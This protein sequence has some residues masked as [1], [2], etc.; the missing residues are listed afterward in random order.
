[1]NSFSKTLLLAAGLLG[2]WLPWSSAQAIQL[3][4][5]YL[6][7]CRREVGV[8]LRADRSSVQMLTLAGA[9]RTFPRFEIIY[10]ALYPLGEAPMTR[11]EGNDE[12]DLVTVQTIFHGERRELVRGWMVD[13]AEE[14]ISFLT[15][16]GEETVIDT[17]DIWDLEMAPLEETVVFPE[18]PVFPYR[19]VHPYPFAHCGYDDEAPAE[20]GVTRRTIFPQTQ[21]GDP[22]LIKKELDRLEEG[23]ARTEGYRRSKKFYPVPQV[24]RNETQLGVGAF[25]GS[26]YG[27]TGTRQNSFIPVLVSGF[28]DGPFAFQ[29]AWVAG[30]APMPFSVHEEAQTQ[31][32]YRLKADYL[33]FSFQY[34]F[35]QVLIGSSNYQWQPGDLDTNDDRWSE[36][37]HLG[38]GYDYGPLSFDLSLTFVGYAVRHEGEFFEDKAE[39]FKFG[40]TYHDRSFRG[41][42]YYGT[43]RDQ[44]PSIEEMIE[45]DE[46]EDL[47]EAEE[48]RNLITDF[49]TKLRFFRMNL[50]FPGMGRD[51][52]TYSLIYRWLEFERQNDLEGL[53]AFSYVGRSVTN[54]IYLDFPLDDELTLSFFASVEALTNRF[55][56][57]GID[58]QDDRTFLKGGT[59]IQLR[60]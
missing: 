7:A 56:V 6:S 32:Y 16:E 20:A 57:T 53:G 50:G 25:F 60:L 30:A 17:G 24:Y 3:T 13:Y 55:G 5:V 39:L 47:E 49:Y 23:Y 46:E 58:K 8:L 44:K 43:G 11:V 29:S 59:T 1:M 40:F 33:H 34:D 2:L 19:F 36:I 37:A 54:A 10:F 48:R 35:N 31:V 27:A 22:L 15:T 9:V 18:R 51:R 21:L 12:V 26:R 14:Q 45:G 4:A 42:F 38:G 41:D 28:S 52:F